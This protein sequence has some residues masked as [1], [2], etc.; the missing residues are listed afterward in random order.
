MKK[1]ELLLILPGTLDEN[2]AAEKSKG[3]LEIVKEVG[4]DAEL[5]VMGKNRLAYPVMQIRYGYFYT[6]VFTAEPA[7]MAELQK[8]LSLSRDLLRATIFNFDSKWSTSQKISYTTNEMGVTTMK[9]S[10]EKMERPLE[11]VEEQPQVKVAPVVADTKIDLKEINKKL[12]EILESN[13][14]PSI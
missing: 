8:K 7:R 1:Y 2:Q 9:Q 13:I 4:E 5:N 14:I 6:V 3:V 10:E 11:R 12:D